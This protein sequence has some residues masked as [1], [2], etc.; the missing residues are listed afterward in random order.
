MKPGTHRPRGICLGCGQSRALTVDGRIYPH[1]VA[2]PTTGLRPLCDGSGRAPR[3]TAW[4]GRMLAPKRPAYALP[5]RTTYS[6]V[7][8]ELAAARGELV[9]QD[10]GD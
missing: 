3:S 4:V 1:R 9:D 7:D 10:D 6:S 8:D 2:S 5:S